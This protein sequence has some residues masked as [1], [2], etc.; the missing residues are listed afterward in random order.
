MVNDP[1]TL[2]AVVSNTDPALIFGPESLTGQHVKLERLT[3]NHFPDLWETLGSH[4]DVFTWWPEGPYSTSSDF[5]RSLNEALEIPR[6]AIYTVLLLSGPSKG[7][8]VG[9]A[10]AQYG[11]DLTDRVSEIGALFSPQLQRT[12]ASTEAMFLLSH[13]IFEKLN[14]RRMAWRCNSLNLASR[15]AAERYGL[16]YEGTFR[17][18]KIMKGRNRD[19]CWYSMIDS[20]WPM[21]K[22]VFEKWLEDG[23]FDEQQ[24]QRSSMTEIRES[25]R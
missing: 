11:E 18:Y 25:L 16:V 9:C 14:Y 21:C 8:A 15:K 20:E 4:D 1:L 7:K 22:K 5:T 10:L 2:A 19:T 12:R 13:L 3:Q 24:R 23:N 6:L 17:Q